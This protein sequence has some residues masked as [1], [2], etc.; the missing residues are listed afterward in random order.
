MTKRKD[1]F[2]HRV[3]HV[4]NKCLMDKGSRLCVASV[5]FSDVLE[6]KSRACRHAISVDGI[7]DDDLDQHLSCLAQGVR[8][9]GAAVFGLAEHA[10]E[11]DKRRQ[12]DNEDNLAIL[13]SAYTHANKIA[14]L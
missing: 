6:H 9:N 2:L 14:S 11:K 8:S 7:L 3:K 10:L 4:D 1:T 12:T 5:G 13:Q